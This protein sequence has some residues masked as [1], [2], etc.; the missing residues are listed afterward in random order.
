ML[1]VGLI[2]I[3]TVIGW[4]VEMPPSTP[5]ELLLANL[6]SRISSECSVPFC[7]TL[8]NHEPISTPLTALSP[9]M[10]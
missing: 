3:L 10:A 7:A 2:A 8:L 1:D 6:P 9:I 4:P 5:P